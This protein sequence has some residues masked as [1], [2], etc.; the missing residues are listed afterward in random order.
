[1]PEFRPPTPTSDYNAELVR[2]LRAHRGRVVE[3]FFKDAPLLILTTSGAR[4]GRR[5]EHPLAYTRDGGRYV[6]LASNGGQP[7]HPAWYH[8]L[9]ADPLVTVEVDGERFAARARVARGEER[10]RLFAAQVERLPAFGEYQRRTRRPIPVII[11][12]RVA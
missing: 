10:A 4:T 2:H 8:N 9:V 11:L 6:V 7:T 5:R 1:M 3:G 12:E